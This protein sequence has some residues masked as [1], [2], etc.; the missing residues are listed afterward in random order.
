VAFVEI[1]VVQ[2]STFVTDSG[3]LEVR[4]DIASSGSRPLFKLHSHCFVTV[5]VS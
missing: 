1:L 2:V 3:T 5:A 4:F